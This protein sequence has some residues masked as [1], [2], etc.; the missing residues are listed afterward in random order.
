MTS[1]ERFKRAFE[2][3]DADRIP[4]TDEP[5]DTTVRRF[6]RFEP[7]VYMDC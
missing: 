7:G 2:H 1:G 6:L 3:R 4:I 5:W